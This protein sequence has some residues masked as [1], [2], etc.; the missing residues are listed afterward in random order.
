[1]HYVIRYNGPLAGLLES[2]FADK[3]LHEVHPREALQSS[4]SQSGVPDTSMGGADVAA[5]SVQQFLQILFSAVPHSLEFGGIIGW[6]RLFLGELGRRGDVNALIAVSNYIFKS[7][8]LNVSGL[9]VLLADRTLRVF[10]ELHYWAN[11]EIHNIRTKDLEYYRVPITLDAALETLELDSAG[12]TVAFTFFNERYLENFVIWLDLYRRN[13][14]HGKHLMVLAIGQSFA[15]KVSAI[16]RQKGANSVNVV[17]WDPPFPLSVSGNGSDLSFLWY[18]K[19]HVASNLVGR[20]LRVVYS[21]LDAYWMKDFFSTWEGI[22]ATTPAD[23]LLSPTHDMPPTAVVRWSFAPC[24]GFFCVEPTHGAKEF[25]RDWRRMTEIMYDDQIALSELLFRC[26]VVWNMIDTS[27]I[28]LTGNTMSASGQPTSFAVLR[29]ATAKRVG[30][31]DPRTIG[32]ATI[33]HPRWVM[34]PDQHKEV[35]QS[36]VGGLGE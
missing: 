12:D 6:S 27:N 14:P 18:I 8:C 20:G 29:P 1:M 5:L 19:V 10:Q 25:L 26:S 28:C 31:A 16:C 30:V 22:R 33:W 3:S 13:D 11:I 7:L 4:Q 24:A 15:T 35:V 36:L 21:D 2:H 17:E 9:P 23:L 32:G 34:N